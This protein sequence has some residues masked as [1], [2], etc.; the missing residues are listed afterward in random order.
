MTQTVDI[1]EHLIGFNSISARSNLDIIGFIEAYLRER[2]FRL[3]RI[4]GVDGEKAGLF[5][6]LGPSG[7]GL[8]LSGHTDVVPTEGQDWT[9]D[10]FRLSQKDGKLFG[11]GTTD[12]K[13][14]L[15]CML[16]AADKAATRDLREPLKLVFSYDEEIGCVGI[17]HMADQLA[18][19]LG[20]PRACLVGEPTEMQVAIGH[21]GKAAIKAVC[22][23]Q[24]GHS[25]L[26]PTFVNSLHL[27][28][29]FVAELRGVQAWLVE[30]GARDTAYDIAYSTV[31]VGKL[32]GGIALNI[33][34]DHAELT[35]EY[36]HL[37]ADDPAHI[38]GLISE[39]ADRVANT[40]HPAFRGAG[41]SLDRFNAY[42]GLDVPAGAD[43]VALGQ[44]LAKTNQ[45][46]KVAFGTEAGVFEG[47]GVPTIVCG[48]GSMVG[49]GHKP[50]EFIAL[51]QL[52]ACDRMMD[53]VLDE[54][55][56]H[57]VWRPLV[58]PV[59]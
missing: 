48:P 58:S 53:R 40:Y 27:A 10:P 57:G 24:S 19:L 18:P 15:A 43:V 52:A 12:M 33:V 20:D 16:R 21:K 46:T 7:G 13:G 39:A 41:I 38:M 51:D 50:D 47:L 35:L 49:Q 3:T 11:R 54:I 2:G 4:T 25:A 22:R 45:V 23:G 14:Y 32:V 17:Q 36:R 34:P 29:D 28:A 59:L 9:C 31:H 1:L 37:A 8:L 42:P 6:E 55:S 30:N 26:A 44:R 56:K 5:A